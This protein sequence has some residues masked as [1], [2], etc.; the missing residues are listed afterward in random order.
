MSDAQPSILVVDDTP[1]NV[2]LLVDMLSA[3]G[4]A[5]V[6]RSQRR[7]GARE[8]RGATRPTWCCSTS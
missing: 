5:R 4:Y 7:R 3:K 1:A 6:V 2:K 8:D